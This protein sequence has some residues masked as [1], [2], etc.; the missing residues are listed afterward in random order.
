MER[1]VSNPLGEPEERLEQP[2]AM[3]QTRCPFFEEVLVAFCRAFPIKK[4]IPSDRIQA[5]CMCTCEEFEDCTLFKEIM[6]RMESAHAATGLTGEQT[7]SGTGNP[8]SHG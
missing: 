3:P 1:K 6:V 5:K 7:S 2:S 8:A 4:M